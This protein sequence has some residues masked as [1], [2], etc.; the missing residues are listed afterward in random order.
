V[1]IIIV[2][3]SLAF[4]EIPGLVNKRY[5]RELVVFSCLFLIAFIL[6]IFQI[7]GVK[8]PSPMNGIK[9]IISDI[10]GLGY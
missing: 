5:W 7:M 10:L 3:I 2:F 4:F 9:Y 6:V 1:C 8:V